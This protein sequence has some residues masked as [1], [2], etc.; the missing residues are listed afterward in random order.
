[1]FSK[2]AFFNLGALFVLW[3]LS[4]AGVIVALP[5]W[6]ATEPEYDEG[7]QSPSGRRLARARIF[8]TAGCAAVWIC[9][10]LGQTLSR[11]KDL[12]DLPFGFW[13]DHPVLLQRLFLPI[14]AAFAAAA[15]LAFQARGR[16]AWIVR[17][18]ASI[19]AIASFIGSVILWSP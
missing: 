11:S 12:P 16:G 6:T 7:V 1:M 13:Q 9:A 14:D 2:Y 4:I 3:G 10:F 15:F 17:V 18:A 19:L 5:V 8:M